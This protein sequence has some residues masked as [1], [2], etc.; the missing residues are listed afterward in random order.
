[1]KKICL[2]F[3]HLQHQDGVA[4]SAVAIANHLTR[5]HLAEVTL[6]PL[7]I[8]DKKAHDLLDAGVKVKPVF[9]FY[10]KGFSKLVHRLPMGLFSRLAFGHETYDIEVAFQY[11]VSQQCVATHHSAAAK[12][13]WMHTYDNGLRFKRE[14]ETM[15]TV[16]CVSRCN[17]ERLHRELP[18]VKTD[19][20]YNPVDDE[21][22]REL[23]KAPIDIERPEGLLFVTVGRHSA[24][25]GFDRL[26]KIVKRLKD[27]GYIFHLWIIGD[28]PLSGELNKLCCELGVDNEVQFLGR[29]NNPH[30]F[31]S[32]AD[33]FICSSFSEGYSTAC[34]EAV[35]LGVP[36]ITTN[37]SGAE[38]I[39]NDAGCGMITEMDDESLYKAIKSICETPTVID[40]WKRTL[41]KTR[42]RFSADV[43]IQRL[44]KLFQLD[45]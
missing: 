36:I 25:K 33:V 17:A 34:T 37:V 16:C 41:L 28:G 15:G 24:E 44:V 11:G 22:V 45:E 40:V 12:Y 9:G 42:E 39:M 43:R 31:T 13:A 10:F 30:K 4:R 35:M 23:G 6:M 21:E 2:M 14:Y 26:I 8:N 20:N 38:E 1:M 32:K 18:L 7:F 3:N 5:M 19:Y 27:E 29:Q